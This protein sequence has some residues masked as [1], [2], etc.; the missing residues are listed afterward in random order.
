[1]TDSFEK[2]KRSWI[3]RQVLSKGT[4]PELAVCQALRASGL[5]FQSNVN[6]VV[7]NPDIA[8]R[9][10]R[11]AIFVNGCFWHWHGCPRCR[12]PESNRAYWQ[13]KISRNVVRDKKHR[14]ELHRKGWK[15]ITIWECDM[16]GG[17]ARI[18]KTV[19]ALRQACT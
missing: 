2:D 8:F 3:M 16:A 18:V 9:K 6:N 1:M 12:M 11:L 14:R 15:Y 4:R 5:R 7:G 19:R 17:I 13:A 10:L